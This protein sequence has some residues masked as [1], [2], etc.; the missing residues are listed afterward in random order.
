V[1]KIISYNSQISIISKGVLHQRCSTLSSG[2]IWIWFYFSRNLHC[3][4]AVQ[5]LI[6]IQFWTAVWL[7]IRFWSRF[8]WWMQGYYYCKKLWFESC[9][10]Q[11]TFLY[12]IIRPLMQLFRYSFYVLFVLD[13]LTHAWINHIFWWWCFAT[14]VSTKHTNEP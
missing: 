9:P 5:A 11:K 6:F 14:T 10:V 7:P 8:R 3:T 1:L 4:R 2:Q 12:Q 13:K